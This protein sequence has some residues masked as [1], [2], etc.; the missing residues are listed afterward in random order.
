MDFEEAAEVAINK[1]KVLSKIFQ[2]KKVP[3]EPSSV[4]VHNYYSRKR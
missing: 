2:Q 3:A 1:N 4:D